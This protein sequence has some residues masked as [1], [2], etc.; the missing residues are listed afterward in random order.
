ML[1]FLTTCAVLALLFLLW[2]IHTARHLTVGTTAESSRLWAMAAVLICVT[3]VAAKLP[4]I[5]FSVRTQSAVQYFAAVMLLT[6]FVGILGARRPGANAWPW[7]VVLP[8]IVVLQWPSLSQLMS[9]N[10]ENP[11]EIPAP[12]MIGFF[13][14][15]VMG[16]GNY[17][18]TINTGA[19]IL[20]GVAAVLIVLPVSDWMLFSSDWCLPSGCLLLTFSSLLLPGRYLQPHSVVE[21]GNED[22]VQ[23]WAD[24]R[25][26]YGTV[27]AKRVMDRLNQFAVREHWEVS[28]S[29]DGFVRNDDGSSVS[30]PGARPVQILCWILRRFLDRQFLRRYLSDEMMPEK[31]VD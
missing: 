20:T 11:I 3:S 19:A 2:Q 23:M 1:V 21:S 13:F 4:W 10:P 30:S 27:W 9:G 29:L 17:F 5:S 15:L 7:F 24:F 28:M 12:T 25:D 31:S 26:I 6:P 8:L 14:V 22:V 16:A 18:G